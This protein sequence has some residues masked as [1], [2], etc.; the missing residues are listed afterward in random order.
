M[1]GKPLPKKRTEAWDAEVGRRIRARRLECGL[2]QTEL[3][4]AIAVSFQQIQKYEKGVNRISAARLQQ[5][6]DALQAPMSFFYGAE[7][8]GPGHFKPS[9][10]FDLLADRDAMELVIAFNRVSNRILRRSFVRLLQRV[11]R[12]K[13][14]SPKKT[15]QKRSRA[16]TDK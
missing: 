5:I 16:G 2:S 13:T 15:N 6:G 7:R 8:S 4:R 10:L 1:S 12:P 9:R 3:A 11:T 14:A